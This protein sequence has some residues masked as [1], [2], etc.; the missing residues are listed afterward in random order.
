MSPS[1]AASIKVRKYRGG[2]IIIPR[3]PRFKTEPT[4]R[5]DIGPG[6]YKLESQFERHAEQYWQLIYNFFP[7]YFNFI[8]IAIINELKRHFCDISHRRSSIRALPG[9]F[10]YNIEVIASRRC[11]GQA[12]GF[13]IKPQHFLPQRYTNYDS[14]SMKMLL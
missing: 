5:E 2:N 1:N 8:I 11:W 3:A 13:S 10:W 12:C 6:F 4:T 14:V 7:F 9:E